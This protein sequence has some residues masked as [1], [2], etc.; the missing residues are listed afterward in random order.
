MQEYEQRSP[1]ASRYIALR[2]LV[3]VA[4]AFVA[5]LG[6]ARAHGTCEALGQGQDTLWTVVVPD[7]FPGYTEAPIQGIGARTNT[8]CAS[9]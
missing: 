2:S 9:G 8:C 4:I 5:N 3:I 1:A 6:S 7:G